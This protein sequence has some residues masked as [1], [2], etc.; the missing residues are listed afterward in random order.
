MSEASVCAYLT[1]LSHGNSVTQYLQKK[2]ANDLWWRSRRLPTRE[3]PEI[4][5]SG[6]HSGKSR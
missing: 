3:D 5:I 2:I 1:D 4:Y 6:S